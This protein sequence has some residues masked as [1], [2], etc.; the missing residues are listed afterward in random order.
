LGLKRDDLSAFKPGEFGIYFTERYGEKPYILTDKNRLFYITNEEVLDDIKQERVK[1]EENWNAATNVS[2]NPQTMESK[3][4][5]AKLIEF[6]LRLR[7]ERGKAILQHQISENARQAKNAAEQARREAEQA[8][9]EA[10]E[11]RRQAAEANWKSRINST[12]E[13]GIAINPRT[14][15]VSPVIY[16]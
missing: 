7:E 10:A 15:E 4:D 1:R 9:F 5:R 12:P 8:R 14:G 13:W 11:A 2:T 6:L 16:P 3:E